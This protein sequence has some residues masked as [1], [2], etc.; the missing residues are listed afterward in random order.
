MVSQAREASFLM[1]RH[2]YN[3]RRTFQDGQWFDSAREANRWNELHLMQRAELIVDLNRP[4]DYEVFPAY[5]RSDG[6]RIRSIKYRPD[7]EYLDTET[8]QRVVE[9]VKGIETQVFKLKR[10][11]FEHRYGIVIRIVK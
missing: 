6:K 10:K 9:D 1:R 2:K 8:G 7:F 5:T 11:L 3:A 4:G